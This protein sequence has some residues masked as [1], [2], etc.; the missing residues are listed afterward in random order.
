MSQNQ[1]GWWDNSGGQ[2]QGAWCDNSGGQQQGAW[3]NNSG[4]QQQGDYGQVLWSQDN[5]GYQDQWTGYGDVG[6]KYND[7]YSNYQYPP[8]TNRRTSQKSVAALSKKKQPSV[9]V[10]SVPAPVED[11][12]YTGVNQSGFQK[13]SRR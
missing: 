3:G 11:Q 10:G 2:Q 4:G 6:R 13:E 7:S 1:G 9:E 8:Y 12:Q 5:Q